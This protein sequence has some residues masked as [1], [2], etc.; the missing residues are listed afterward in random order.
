MSRMASEP[1]AR[2]SRHPADEWRGPPSY[3]P[4]GYGGGVS[5]VVVLAGLA[6]VGLGVLAWHYLGPDLVR[7]MKIREM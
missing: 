2:Y 3:P 1:R 7:Y 5:P 4:P 6:A